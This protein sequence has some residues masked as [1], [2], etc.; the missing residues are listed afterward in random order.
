L[1]LFRRRR[2]ASLI[3]FVPS[4]EDIA[5]AGQRSKA[6]PALQDTTF[7]QGK[8]RSSGH[9][10]KSGIPRGGL[11]NAEKNGNRAFVQALGRSRRSALGQVSLGLAYERPLGGLPKDEREAARLYKL[12]ADQGVNLR[13][14]CWLV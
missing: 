4:D 9:G 11:K 1:L 8:R 6:L 14:A 5:A 10:F 12:A 3:S 13:R 7:F 2:A